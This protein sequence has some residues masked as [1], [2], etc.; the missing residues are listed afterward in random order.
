[1]G[2]PEKYT[3]YWTIFSGLPFGVAAFIMGIYLF[4]AIPSNLNELQKIEGKINDFGT[5]V[6]YDASIN[7]KGKVFYIKFDEYIE[8]YTDLAKH[9]E[10]LEKYC[11]NNE[12]LNNKA[13]VWTEKDEDYIEQI[14]INNEIVI[15]Y[16]PPY[17]AAWT[18]LIG[19][20]VITIGAILYLKHNINYIKSKSNFLRKILGGNKNKRD[21]TK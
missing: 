10:L 18:F 12:V 7:A 2:I 15:S 19:G 20:I 5:K 9:Q 13:I 16:E 3:Y 17:W 14:S 11:K 6:I 8:Y 4:F 21:K 1:M